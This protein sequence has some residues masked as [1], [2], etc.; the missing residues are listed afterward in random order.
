MGTYYEGVRRGGGGE[1]RREG[2]NEGI[3]LGK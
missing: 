2:G 1:V 3:E